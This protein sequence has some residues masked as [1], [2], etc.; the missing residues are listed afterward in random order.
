MSLS[1]EY[2]IELFNRFEA[3][4]A[5]LDE[6][7]RAVCEQDATLPCWFQVP[8]L[9]SCSDPIS[10]REK[11][12]AF[13]YQLEYLPDQEPREI[14]IGA[15]V[16][17]ASDSTLKIIHQ[18][19]DCKHR[20]KAAMLALKKAKVPLVHSELQDYFESALSK[21]HP[22]VTHALGKMGLARLHL[23]QC[24]RLI[25][26]LTRRPLKVSWTWAHTKAITRVTV[27]EVEALLQQKGPSDAVAYQLSKLYSLPEQEP[28]AIVRTLAP[29]LRTNIVLPERQGTRRLM[30][31]GTVPLFYPAEDLR[32][33]ELHS[34]FEKHERHKET[35]IRSDV[36]LESEPFLSS[37]RVYRY[38]KNT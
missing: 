2:Q 11:A 32:L 35:R 20:F 28:L 6:L 10:T 8:P 5:A 22:S 34:P 31:K 14:L 12:S 17:A 37:L 4:Q 1:A 30:L 15:G 24:Y 21:R 7:K 33:P 26:C 16:F 36:Q 29:H 9:L 27:K 3:L 18:V 38:V 23:K 25:P 13:L 19:N